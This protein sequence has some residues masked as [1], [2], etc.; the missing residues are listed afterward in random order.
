MSASSCSKL[1]QT[2]DNVES[3]GGRY[4]VSVGYVQPFLLKR[5]GASRRKRVL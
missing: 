1:V 4:E 3:Q 5:I 2:C